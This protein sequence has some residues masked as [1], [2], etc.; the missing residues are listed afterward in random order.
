MVLFEASR[1]LER[2]GLSDVAFELASAP[3]VIR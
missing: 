1:R 2:T 3:C